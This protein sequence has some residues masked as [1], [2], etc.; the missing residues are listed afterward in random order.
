MTEKYKRL[1]E[2]HIQYTDLEQQ[3]ETIETEMAILKS[4]ILQHFSENEIQ[5]TSIAGFT[6]YRTSKKYASAKNIKELAP[7]LKR[8]GM[9]SIIAPA[10]NGQTLSAWIRE[11]EKKG[12]LPDDL[13]QAETNGW[14]KVTRTPMIAMRGA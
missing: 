3:L 2:L 8:Y 4:E 5:N 14:L 13:Q 1:T 6:I 9:E 10:I 7:I 12:P 11:L